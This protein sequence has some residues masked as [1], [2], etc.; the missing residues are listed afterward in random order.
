MY[1]A[2]IGL[3]EKSSENDDADAYSSR[4]WSCFYL[5][6]LV[7]LIGFTYEFFISMELKLQSTIKTKH[8]TVSWYFFFLLVWQ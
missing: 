6:A 1:S 2:V 8:S 7:E 4:H 3:K 5:V